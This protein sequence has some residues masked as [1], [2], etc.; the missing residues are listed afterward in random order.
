MRQKKKFFAIAVDHVLPYGD[1]QSFFVAT[2]AQ[3]QPHFLLNSVIGWLLG[4]LSPRYLC[5]KAIAQTSVVLLA[6]PIPSHLG[7][8]REDRR[9]AIVL[10]TLLVAVSREI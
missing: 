4:Q 8:R 2:N 1:S 7:L 5:P 6:R 10:V 3:R 9:C